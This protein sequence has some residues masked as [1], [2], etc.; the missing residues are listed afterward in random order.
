MVQTIGNPF[1]NQV[2][3]VFSCEGGI[4]VKKAIKKAASG[5]VRDTEKT[6]FAELSGNAMQCPLSDD[7]L[8]P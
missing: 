2:S 8:V 3:T 5:L 6:W 1:L 4:G 7:S